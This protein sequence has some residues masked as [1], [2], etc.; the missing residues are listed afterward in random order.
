MPFIVLLT[1]LALPLMELAVLIKVGQ[2]IGLARTL[3][4]LLAMAALGIALLYWQGWS[5]VRRAQETA[6]R[7]EVPVGPMLEGVLLVAA[8]V[9]LLAPGLITDAFALVLLVPPL[10]RLIARRIIRRAVVAGNVH[11]ETSDSRQPRRP[12]KGIGPGPVIEG[13]YVRI[14]DDPPKRQ[15][16]RD[17][18]PE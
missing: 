4:L 2:T 3:L 1:G 15:P 16:G 17:G 7:G 5:A 11:V 10:R 9:L 13:D 12:D 6:L 14:D 18:K 8:G